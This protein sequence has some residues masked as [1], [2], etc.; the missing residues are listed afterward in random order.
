MNLKINKM[1]T[2]LEKLIEQI[3][4]RIEKAKIFVENQDEIGVILSTGVMMGFSESKLLAETLLK[5]EK[6]EQ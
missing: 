2:A 5:N 1:K 3:D 4:E 6:T